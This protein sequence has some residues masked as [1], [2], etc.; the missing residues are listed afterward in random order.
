MCFSATAS[1]LAAGALSSLGLA[2]SLAPD[3]VVS[4]LVT[5]STAIF[6]VQQ[7]CE[8]LIWRKQ[9]V[10]LAAV[11]FATIAYVVWPL[12]MP[13]LVLAYEFE[14]QRLG[15]LRLVAGVAAAYAAVTIGL[16]VRRG[17][18]LDQQDRHLAYDI[19]GLDRLTGNALLITYLVCTVGPFL[20]SSARPW[21]VF[22]V[23][24]LAAF[25]VSDYCFRRYVISVWCF[26]AATLFIGANL[27]VRGLPFHSA[28][29]TL[30]LTLGLF[31]P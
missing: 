12:F 26:L 23:G 14:P 9:A 17:V 11:T 15:L 21:Q 29:E 20:L 25:A 5:V 3:H 30:A 4:P 28:T 22:G 6:G 7:V 8:G 27:L 2:S 10:R 13:V 1:F 19:P 24:L 16:M 18:T 31:V